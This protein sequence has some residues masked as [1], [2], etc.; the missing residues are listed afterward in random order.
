MTMITDGQIIY[1]SFVSGGTI[2]PYRGL[3]LIIGGNTLDPDSLIAAC[4]GTSYRYFDISALSAYLTNNNIPVFVDCCF[5]DLAD[6]VY[7]NKLY[8][9]FLYSATKPTISLGGTPTW[10]IVFAPNYVTVTAGAS[11]L[12]LSSAMRLYFFN[13]GEGKDMQLDPLVVNTPLF[14]N[15]LVVPLTNVVG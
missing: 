9:N 15:N 4:R 5:S 13:I 1:E 7:G 3:G 10:C 6:I 12:S 11:A 8:I 2:S 14:L